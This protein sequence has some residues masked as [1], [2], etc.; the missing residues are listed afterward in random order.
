MIEAIWAVSGECN[1]GNK[2]KYRNTG[3]IKVGPE[4]RQVSISL[5]YILHCYNDEN[6]V[7]LEKYP[8]FD[9][10]GSANRPQLFRD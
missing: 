9:P 6:E 2:G 10:S 5:L 1:F 4:S 3:H 7:G 8:Y